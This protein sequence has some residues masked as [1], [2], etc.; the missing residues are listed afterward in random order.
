MRMTFLRVAYH[1]GLLVS[2]V[3]G[4]ALVSLGHGVFELDWQKAFSEGVGNAHRDVL[5][6]RGVRTVLALSV[7]GI[8]SVVGTLFQAMTRNPLADPF[9]LGVSGGAAVGATGAI[10]MGFMT[11][12]VA[13][14]LLPIPPLAAFFGAL[15]SLALVYR[16]AM[17]SGRLSVYRLLLVGV[18]LNFFASALVLVMKTFGGALEVRSL[19][20][21]LVGTLSWASL[22]EVILCGIVALLGTLWCLRWVIAL[23]VISVGDAGAQLL[24]V[25][26]NRVQKELFVVSSLMVGVAVSVSGLVGFVGLVVPHALRRIYGSDHR[27]LIPASFLGGGVFLLFCDLVARS[28][29]PVLG[30]DAPVGVVTAFIGGPV[31]LWLL[32][33]D[34]SGVRF[35]H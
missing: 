17:V 29:F 35:E 19:L 26:V 10:T 11:V 21:W 22:E 18:V 16:L 4:V 31:F 20:L 23:N 12:G 9:L 2:L 5:V 27:L 8:L 15:G 25:D 28:L 30:S 34:E 1:V 32:L 13:G 7:G 6:A 24:G 14:V 33:R 3:V